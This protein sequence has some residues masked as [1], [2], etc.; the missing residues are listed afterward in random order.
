MNIYK[1]L[2]VDGEGV[3]TTRELVV[4]AVQTVW[5][6]PETVEIRG[7]NY[8]DSILFPDLVLKNLIKLVRSQAK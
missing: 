3:S 8:V 6:N 5:G 1:T 2:V 7:F 4:E